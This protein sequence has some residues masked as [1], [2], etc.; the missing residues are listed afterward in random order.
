MGNDEAMRRLVLGGLAA[1]VLVAGCGGDVDP[2]RTP[3]GMA[4]VVFLEDLYNGRVQR[5]YETLHPAY[6]RIVPR[7]QFVNCTREASL[8]GLDSIEI[9]DVY[10]DPVRIPGAGTVPAKA[11]RVR[12]TSTAG[13][14]TTFVSHEVK[15]GPRWRWV[16][17]DTALRAYRDGKC[18]SA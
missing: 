1:A 16:L 6:R 8:G 5:A 12:L 11:V 10:D 15:V 7:N 18:P 13:D 4:Q 3:A 2:A 14:A 9:L 17:N